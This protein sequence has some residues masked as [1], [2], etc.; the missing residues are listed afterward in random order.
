MSWPFGKHKRFQ[1]V[2]RVPS[3][4]LSEEKPKRNSQKVGKTSLVDAVAQR[5]RETIEREGLVAGDRLPTEP[6]LLKRLG[7]SRSVLR[8]AVGQLR[9]IGLLTVKHGRG[10]YVA[11]ADM[12]MGCVKLFR[13]ALTIS[14][15]ELIQFTEFRTAIEA[16]AVRRATELATDQQVDE[17]ESLCRS[18]D[19][20]GLDNA[21]AM[22]R[23][24][25]F[26]LR[27][28]ELGGNRP[29]LEVMRVVQ[30]LIFEGM[31]RTTASPRLCQY[32]LNLHLAVTRAIRARDPEAA[33]AAIRKHMDEL[34][35]RLREAEKREEK[36]PKNMRE[37][38][39]RTRREAVDDS[40]KEPWRFATSRGS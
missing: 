33:E 34:T 5:I 3:F 6:E 28:V 31:V 25:A 16:P 7:V 37:S 14:S 39:G 20:V 15:Q 30:E 32:S 40:V 11:E 29:M 4:C 18:I 13:S 24:L 9:T 21:E 8:E 22:R 26:H 27:I 1:E 12:L 17:L 2:I 38:N 35:E 23:D 36:R 19:V 10:M